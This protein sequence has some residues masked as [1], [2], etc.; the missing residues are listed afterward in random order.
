MNSLTLNIL[1]GTII[2]SIVLFTITGL[3]ASWNVIY[4]KFFKDVNYKKKKD[5]ILKKLEW[6][7]NLDIEEQ[8]YFT[9]KIQKY[10]EF[11][12]NDIAMQDK[13]ISLDEI[14]KTE[15]I[16][17][18]IDSMIELEVYS[19][20]RVN[21]SLNSKYDILKIDEDVQK[22]ATNVYA[23]LNNQISSSNLVFSTEYIMKY[24]ISKSFNITLRTVIEINAS[25]I[26]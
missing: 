23:G 10:E 16:K 20:L 6:M 7:K 11:L 24:I 21:I 15:R 17:D 12:I 25:V 22:I 18:L 9:K 2:V 5:R 26:E 3:V 19:A 1:L 13:N 8:N 14:E 4:I